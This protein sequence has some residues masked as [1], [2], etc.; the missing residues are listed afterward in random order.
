[1]ILVI[2]EGLT[3]C[4]FVLLSCVI[5]IANGAHNMAFFYEEE[6]QNRVEELGLISK[7]QIKENSKK[8]ATYG[9]L[10]YFVMTVLAVYVLNKTKGFWDPFWQICAILLIEGIFD[11]LFID[12]YWVNHTKAWEI[13]GTEDLKPYINKKAW[14]KKWSTTLIGYPIIAAIISLALSVIIK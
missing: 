3:A 1:M 4:L 12:C 5:G 2:F 7:N 14:I 9:I 8:F 10:P 13:P 6:V 11:R